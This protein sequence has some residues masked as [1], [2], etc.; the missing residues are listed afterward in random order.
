MTEWN[1][2]LARYEIA[3]TMIDGERAYA[4]ENPVGS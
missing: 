4:T 1:K 3:R 2:A